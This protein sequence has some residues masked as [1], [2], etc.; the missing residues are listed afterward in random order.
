VLESVK[1][2]GIFC[3]STFEKEHRNDNHIQDIRTTFDLE[4][5]W[6]RMG[7]KKTIADY[8]MRLGTDTAF[9]VSSPVLAL[10]VF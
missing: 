7:E 3:C 10:P 9:G 2:V 4:C 8:K 5:K 1:A 6:T